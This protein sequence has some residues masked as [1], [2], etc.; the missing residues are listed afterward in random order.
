M[1]HRPRPLD[2][3]GGRSPL[4]TKDLDLYPQPP[5]QHPLTHTQHGRAPMA[6]PPLQE[7]SCIF[8]KCKTL[9]SFPLTQGQYVLASKYSSDSNKERILPENTFN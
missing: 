2:D 4:I 6:L 3:S 7:L 9:D 8:S 1:R 5:D